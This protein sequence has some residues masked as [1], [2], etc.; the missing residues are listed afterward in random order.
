M[1]LKLG[2]NKVVP[3]TWRV[4]NLSVQLTARAMR[5]LFILKGLCFRSLADCRVALAAT[6]FHVMFFIQTDMVGF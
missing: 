1:K 4:A 2:S 6:D 3:Y 5:F